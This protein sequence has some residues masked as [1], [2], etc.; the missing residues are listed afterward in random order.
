ML[1]G[2]AALGLRALG[3]SNTRA[4]SLRT[5]QVHAAAYQ[6][7]ETEA[8]QVRQLLGLC[9][10]GADSTSWVNGGR[11]ATD[12]TKACLRQTDRTVT[13]ALALLANATRSTSRRRVTT[14]F[15]SRKSAG[16]T[17]R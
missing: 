15:V 7:L 1:V 17:G 14:Q 9:A 11:Q 3:Q 10:G 5:L 2:V 16:L 8:T 4:E 12:T 13:S 6:E